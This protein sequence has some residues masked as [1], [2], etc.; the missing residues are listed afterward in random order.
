MTDYYHK[1]QKYRNKYL[2]IAGK[3]QPYQED[4]C[5]VN[6]DTNKCWQVELGEGD[7]QCICNHETDRCVKKHELRGSRTL[8]T[9]LQNKLNQN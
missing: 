3:C 7:N 2:Q 9:K 5:A 8:V 6:Q 1:Y 4:D